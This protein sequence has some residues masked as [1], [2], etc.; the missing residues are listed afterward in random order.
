MNR[1]VFYTFEGFTESPTNKECENIQIL[2]FENGKNQSE[3]K[4]NLIKE[5]KWIEQ[6]GFDI[7]KILSKQLLTDENREVIK[8]LVDYFEDKERKYCHENISDESN[9]IFNILE[10]ISEIIDK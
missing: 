8:N 9:H 2:G 10:K 4:N 7:T 1:Y 6:K 5:N 3:A